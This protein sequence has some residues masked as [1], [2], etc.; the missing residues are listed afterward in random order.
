M[1]PFSN[2]QFTIQIQSV[3]RTRPSISC[4]FQIPFN[5]LSASFRAMNRS[6]LKIVNVQGLGSQ[7]SLPI[8]EPEKRT[9]RDSKPTKNPEHKAEANNKSKESSNQNKKTNPRRRQRRK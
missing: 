8:I 9:I 3:R 6:G 5:Q 4:Q 2:R 1:G 7:P